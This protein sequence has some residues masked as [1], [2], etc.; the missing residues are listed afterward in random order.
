M[1]EFGILYN[2]ISIETILIFKSKKMYDKQYAYPG[3]KNIIKA[4]DRK[5]A[6]SQYSMALSRNEWLAQCKQSRILRQETR[7]YGFNC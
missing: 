3:G 2:C 7:Y 5:L 6:N 4:K 1:A